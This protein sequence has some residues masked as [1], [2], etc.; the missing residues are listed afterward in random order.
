[1]KNI[2]IFKTF[3]CYFKIF[4]QVF[5]SSLAVTFRLSDVKDKSLVI[6]ALIGAVMMGLNAVM[7]FI[8]RKGS[9]T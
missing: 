8:C 1:M 3:K 9:C 2:F 6:S 7:N 5:I 4:I